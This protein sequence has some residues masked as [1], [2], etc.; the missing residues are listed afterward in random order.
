MGLR[1]VWGLGEVIE[2]FVPTSRLTRV[3]LPTFGRP[4]TATKPLLKPF[5]DSSFTDPP[6]R[7]RAGV[8]RRTDISH[9]RPRR[10]ARRPLRSRTRAGPVGRHRTGSRGRRRGL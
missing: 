3:D 2:T 8:Y 1:V 6:G 7:R 9:A 10:R 5:R 4:T